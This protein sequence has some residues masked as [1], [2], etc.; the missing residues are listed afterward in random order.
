MVVYKYD[1]WYGPYPLTQ[2]SINANVLTDTLGN[3]CLS[4]RHTYSSPTVN[5]VGRAHDQPVHDRLLDHLSDDLSVCNS[6]WVMYKA[7]DIATYFQEC[8]DYHTFSPKLNKC[9]PARLPGSYIGCPVRG[10]DK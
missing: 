1:T 7:T 9:H 10:C 3:Y 2:A 5:Y 8:R 6:F 4:L